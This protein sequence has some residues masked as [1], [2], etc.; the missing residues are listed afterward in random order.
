MGRKRPEEYFTVHIEE[1]G[2]FKEKKS[3]LEDRLF[4]FRGDLES[5][6]PKSGPRSGHPYQTI[7]SQDRT[8][9][10]IFKFIFQL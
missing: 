9:V 4:F 3:L 1:I 2:E 7:D 5:D 10:E 6:Y 8:F